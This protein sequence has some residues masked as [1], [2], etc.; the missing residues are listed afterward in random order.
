MRTKLQ[1]KRLLK[2]IN[3]LDELP[4]EK[5]NFSREVTK[6]HTNHK[7]C[8]TVG[9]AI[10]WTPLLFPRLV[11]WNFRPN[12]T[13]ETYQSDEDFV[14]FWL[15]SVGPTYYREVA[16]E[17]FGIPKNSSFGSSI[18][19]PGEQRCVDTDLPNCSRDATP[20]E[21]ATMLRKYRELFPCNQ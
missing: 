2:L 4:P 5:F 3:F 12:W 8:A 15:K 9:C 1:D 13:D 14:G 6:A 21:V 19:F 16:E 7:Q 18:F 17:L 10:G 20:Q 11:K